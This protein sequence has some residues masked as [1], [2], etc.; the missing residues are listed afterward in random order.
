[1][2]VLLAL[3]PLPDGF[4]AAAPGRYLDAVRVHFSGV[5]GVRWVPTHRAYIGPPE[6]IHAAAAPLVRAGVIKLS[7]E[8]EAV[9]SCACLPL[10]PP[11][12]PPGLRAY[13]AVGTAWIADRLQAT[14]AALL[15]DEMG[16][17]KTVQAVAAVDSLTPGPVLV[18]APAVVGAHW[19]EQL[20]RWSCDPTRY[21]VTSYEKF[22]RALRRGEAPDADAL[23]LDEI[24]YCSNSRAGRSRAVRGW[25]E[26]RR[27]GPYRRAGG[28]PVVG[29]SGTP[30]TTR[31][32]DLH[33]PLDLLWPGRWGSWWQ[34][35]R[36]YC[37]GRYEEI[38]AIGKAVWRADGVSRADELAARLAPLMLRRTKVEVATDLP[39]RQRVVVPV[40]L[41]KRA[42]A[43]ARKASAAIDWRSAAML[44]RDLTTL[45]GGLEAYK[46]D[47]AEQLARDAL[48]AGHRPLLL[49]VR[50]ATA[51]ELARRLGAALADGDT[52]PQKRA[53]TLQA[54]ECGVS[55][56]YAVTTG[57]DLVAFDV[58]IFV[59][60]DW[61]PSTLL[62]A[63]A[64]IHRIGQRRGVV[65]YYLVGLGTVDEI[66]RSRVIERLGTFTA[67]TGSGGDEQQ[68]AADLDGETEESLISAIVAGV[69]QEAA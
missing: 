34:F 69:M 47:A 65:V 10:P 4:M 37:G 66:I 57:I 51:R 33:N 49:T 44:R 7:A 60:L 38:E 14:G 13:Q 24:H 25:L 27:S 45:L 8:P 52:V 46:L 67:I 48:T 31:P 35:T 22:S 50:K 15:A 18:I 11:D 23:V 54:A 39:P 1:M 17:G 5:P 42:A 16:L 6:A 19:S 64:R 41:P 2:T 3:R 68:L 20:Q 21:T 59:G 30:M 53:A 40:E 43:A 28:L 32:R 61:V 56:V 9:R 58:L 29:L 36:R 55:T 63:E 26:A 62:Q 12:V